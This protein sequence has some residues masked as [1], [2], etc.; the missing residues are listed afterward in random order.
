V[1]AADAGTTLVDAADVGTTLVDAADAG[2]T[3]VDAAVAIMD[4]VIFSEYAGF[5]R[6]SHYLLLLGV[7]KR[8]FSQSMLFIS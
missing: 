6:V 7:F 5:Q 3:L 4:W 2:T 1:D 8:F